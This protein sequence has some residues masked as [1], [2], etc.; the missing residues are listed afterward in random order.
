[1]LEAQLIVSSESTFTKENMMKDTIIPI[2][3]EENRYF[4]VFNPSGT[5]LMTKTYNQLTPKLFKTKKLIYFY[6]K[7]L[8][9]LSI[10]NFLLTSVI[11]K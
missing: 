2:V 1:M 7:D 3:L 6:T 4:L 5:D 11:F 10:F 9:E 8:T